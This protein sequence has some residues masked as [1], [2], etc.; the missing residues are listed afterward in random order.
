MLGHKHIIIESKQDYV[1][2]NE[3]LFSKEKPNTQWTDLA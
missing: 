1:A 2:M 3:P